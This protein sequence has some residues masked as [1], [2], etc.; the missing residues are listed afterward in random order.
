MVLWV[1]YFHDCICPMLTMMAAS[2][3]CLIAY[4]VNE[5]T[6]CINCHSLVTSYLYHFDYGL[7]FCYFPR[8]VVA[9]LSTTSL[10]SFFFQLRQELGLHFQ[11]DI[12]SLNKTKNFQTPPINLAKSEWRLKICPCIKK[13][14]FSIL[15]IFV[16]YFLLHRL[17]LSG[18][19]KHSTSFWYYSNTNFFSKIL[20]RDRDVGK[21]VFLLAGNCF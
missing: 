21:G 2:M 19:E 3:F 9:A 14:K 12:L 8:W 17:L 5:F 1:R 16:I 6:I 7:I 13:V 11:W 4:M 20:S 15:I 18:F 10:C